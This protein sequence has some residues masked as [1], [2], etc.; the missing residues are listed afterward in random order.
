M[1]EIRPEVIVQDKEV[2]EN[3]NVAIQGAE[4]IIGRNSEGNVNNRNVLVRKK[5]RR[6][7]GFND[8]VGSSGSNERPKKRA[9]E[10]NDL[11]GIDRLIGIVNSLPSQSTGEDKEASV[12]T[13]F[14]TP[15]LNKSVGAGGGSG[16]VSRNMEGRDPGQEVD[17]N[18]ILD[19][20]YET[21]TLAKALGAENIEQ[22]IPKVQKVISNEG[23]QVMDQ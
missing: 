10:D 7:N 23:F 2:N 11:F 9:R 20:V 17:S 4:F 19:E 18:E 22:F 14:C 12:S 3:D 16:D 5:Y 15:D 6:K 21:V 1:G 13:G 8:R